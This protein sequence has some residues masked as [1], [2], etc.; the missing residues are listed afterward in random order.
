[1]LKIYLLFDIF[2][3]HYHVLQRPCIHRDNEANAFAN[4]CLQFQLIRSKILSI[5]KD[6][7]LSINKYFSRSF[8][9]NS[10]EQILRHC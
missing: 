3:V 1:M 5:L 4:Y 6:N 2:T 9:A 8:S 10:T 7:D